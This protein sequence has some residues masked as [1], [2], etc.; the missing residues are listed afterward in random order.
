MF[1]ILLQF[2][3]GFHLL[4]SGTEFESC[5]LKL[6]ALNCELCVGV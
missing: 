3:L 5:S 2:L 4:L 1:Y 6:L